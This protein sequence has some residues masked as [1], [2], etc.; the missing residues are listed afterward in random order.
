MRAVL[1]AFPMVLFLAGCG[2]GSTM[3][4]ES[5]DE[6]WVS[7]TSAMDTAQ[8]EAIRRKHREGNAGGL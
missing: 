5:R 3:S 2:G 7:P 8:A 4:V 6:N 1:F